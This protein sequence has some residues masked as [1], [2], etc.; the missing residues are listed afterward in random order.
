MRQTDKA[1]RLFP[2]DGTD[3]IDQYL[4]S[5]GLETA[6]EIEGIPSL[7]ECRRAIAVLDSI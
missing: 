6:D 1:A 3:R 2:L 5:L 4:R 7:E